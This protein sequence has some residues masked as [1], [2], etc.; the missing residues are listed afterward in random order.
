MKMGLYLNK[1]FKIT[2]VSIIS[3]SQNRAVALVEGLKLPACKVRDRGFEPYSGLLVSKKQ[4]VSSSFTR[5]DSI[6]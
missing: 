6:L 1:E 5:E 3:T 4:N 2:L